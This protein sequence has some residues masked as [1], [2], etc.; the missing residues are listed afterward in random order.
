MAKP[1][2]WPTDAVAAHSNSR[3]QRISHP[4]LSSNRRRTRRSPFGAIAG[5]SSGVL[6]LLAT[7]TAASSTAD[8]SPLVAQP[9]PPSF[10]CPSI[11]R[12]VYE[13]DVNLFSESIAESSGAVLL[14]PTETKKHRRRRELAD[15]YEKGPDGKWR[16]ADGYTLYGSTMCKV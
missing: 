13:D 16:Q 2:G 15:K 7:I 3:S 5:P 10:L 8:G 12:D 11:E 4:Q 1:P 9:T 6:S 14:A